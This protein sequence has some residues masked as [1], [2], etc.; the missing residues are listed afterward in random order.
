MKTQMT[1]Q[2]K[3]PTKSRMNALNFKTI[4]T[5]LKKELRDHLRDRRTAMMIFVSSV[6]VGPLVLI[7]MSYFI[8]SIEEKAEKKEVF[9]QNIVHAPQLANFMARQDFTVKEP[10]PDFRELIGQ[11]KHDAVLVIPNDFTEKFVT[12]KADVELVY[13]DTRQDASA[14]SIGIL[15][16]VVQGFNRE[17]SGQRL[18]AHGISGKILTAVEIQETNMGTPA[19]RAAMLL[20]IIPWLTLIV[21]ITG[22]M[23]VAIDMTAGERERG[24]LEPLLMNPI[25]RTSMIIG[26]WLAVACYGMGIVLLLLAGFWAT[27]TFYPLP[28]IASV[29]TLSSAQYLGFAIMLLP[30]TPAIGSLQM[31]IATYG[32]SF[33][34]AQTYVSYLYTVVSFIPVIAMFAQLKDAT[35]QLYVPMLGQMMVLTRILRGEHLDAMHFLIPLGI[36]LA[37]ALFSVAMLTRLMGQEKIIFGRS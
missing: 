16:R 20:F 6:A 24:S 22:C 1:T 34:E 23:A 18:V 10:K 35:W 30:F 14:Q 8:S 5:V 31:L 12:G 19:Q 7:G 4:F 32:R 29:V 13:D 27:L 17:V 37:I 25:A 9:V 33:K 21:G 11:G 26:K 15:R 3:T 36:C 2:A 28:K